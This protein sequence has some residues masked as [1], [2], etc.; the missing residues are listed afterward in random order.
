M[1]RGAEG[2][3]LYIKCLQLVLRHQLA[4]LL[5]EKNL[6]AELETVVQDLWTLRIMHLGDKISNQFQETTSQTFSTQETDTEAEDDPLVLSSRRNKLLEMP[7]LIDC[8][9]L[10]YLGMLTLRL[11]VTPGDIYK[12]TIE[13]NMPYMNAIRLLP[14]SMRA[15]LPSTYHSVF[16]PYALLSLRRFYSS[17]ANLQMAMEHKFSIAWPALNVPVLLLQYLKHLA[18]PLELFDATIRLGEKLGYDFALYMTPN[19]RLRVFDLPEARLISCL[20]ICV[21]L[22]YPFNNTDCYPRTLIEPA[23]TGIDWKIWSGLIQQQRGEGRSGGNRYTTELLSQVEENDVF[24]MSND[25]LDQY[26]DFYLINFMDEANPQATEVA[27]NFQS[28]L[29]KMFP[30]PDAAVEPRHSLTG[31]RHDQKLELVKAVHSATKEVP[32]CS[33]DEEYQ[34][35]P[36][37][38]YT[39]HTKDNALPSYAR[40][41]FEEAAKVSGLTVYMLIKCVRHIERKIT[42]EHVTR[43]EERQWHAESDI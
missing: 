36:G 5:R 31:Q 27:D 41:F 39:G 21:K 43:K 22:M 8:L 32:L 19:R 12:W 25:Q 10:C 14:P 35:K 11:P 17:A 1:Y 26:L 24:L 33:D 9:A 29:Y 15:R 16:S 37:T 28:A 38:R 2:T 30:V 20:V 42:R 34:S 40:Q 6:P 7:T 3:D 23:A 4:F 13:E 18:L